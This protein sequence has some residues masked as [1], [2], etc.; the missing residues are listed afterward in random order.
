MR[1]RNNLTIIIC[2][3]M[4]SIS[5][6]SIAD[7]QFIETADEY[8][9]TMADLSGKQSFILNAK[10][11]DPNYCTIL[12]DF[13]DGNKTI[14]SIDGDK[15]KVYAQFE[16]DEMLGVL[17]RMLHV[18][19]DIENTLPNGKKLEYKIRLSENRLVYLHS[20]NIRAYFSLQLQ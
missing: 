8:L 4:L 20:D 5:S 11:S 1:I 9:S 18:F 2:V 14:I 15:C 19:N 3:L 12:Y 17:Y 6:L 7:T 13:S 16:N 10:N